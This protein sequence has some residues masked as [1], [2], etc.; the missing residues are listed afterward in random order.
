MNKGQKQLTATE[1][2]NIKYLLAEFLTNV[3]N[4]ELNSSGK[5]YKK[6]WLTKVLNKLN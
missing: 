3:E 5:K 4:I 6:I 1:C 2:I